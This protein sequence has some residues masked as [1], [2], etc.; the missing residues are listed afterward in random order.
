M[1]FAEKFFR[2]PSSE[3]KSDADFIEEQKAKAAEEGVENVSDG[4]T[5]EEARD[6]ARQAKW[7]VPSNDDPKLKAA[8]T[9]AVFFCIWVFLLTLSIMGT[10]FKLL[11]GKDSA[12]M[13]DVADNP[14]SALL[15]GGSPPCSSSLPRPLPPSLSPWLV[16]MSSPS[17]SPSS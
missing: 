17:T 2:P 12:K 6:A 8:L 3:E 9:L 14:I 1:F 5:P 11:G 10:G 16:P 15:I 4:M 7:L 13:F